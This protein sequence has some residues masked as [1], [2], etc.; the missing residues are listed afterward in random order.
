MKSEEDKEMIRKLLFKR[1]DE[2]PLKAVE[3][4]KGGGP[5]GPKG[6][7]PNI[8]PPEEPMDKTLKYAIGAFAV[9]IAILLMASLSNSN[10]FYV[11]QNEEMVDVWQGTF[12][13]MG[14]TLLASISSPEMIKDLPKQESY[15]RKQAFGILYDDMLKQADDVL[16]KER[17]PDLKAA[18]CY[19]AN[20]F[21]YALSSSQRKAV[22][23]RLNSISF[24]VLCGKANFA[25]GKATMP[26]FENARAFLAE[27]VP[28]ASTDLQ[29]DVLTKRIAAVEY[30]MA[31]SKISKGEKKLADLYRDALHR[32]LRI[33]KQYSPEKSE[34]IDQQIVK[35]KKWLG[36]FDKRHVGVQY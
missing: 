12:S 6:G 24:L 8:L 34:E 20:A 36:E 4:E 26:G 2:G 16:N 33:A 22:Q 9:V 10:K 28:Y 23:M 25:L 5:S 3:P 30:A 7:V 1:F 13:P 27:A 29:R 32:H 14:K 19:L 18:K 17:I 21:K 35:I 31:T 15:T 11:E